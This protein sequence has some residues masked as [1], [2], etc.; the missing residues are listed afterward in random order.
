MFNESSRYYKL[1]NLSYR[2]RKSKKGNGEGG[3]II[4]YKERRFLPPL[5]NIT[6]MQEVTVAPGERLDNVAYRTLGDPEQFWR[7]C[8]ANE[9]MHPLELASEPG[10]ILKVGIQKIG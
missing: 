1:R 8:D 3:D 6:I 10:K 2:E 9:E 7:I 5:R 4:V